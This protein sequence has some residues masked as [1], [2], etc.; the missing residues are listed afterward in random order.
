[1]SLEGTRLGAAERG[2]G[3]RCISHPTWKDDNGCETPSLVLGERNS[4]LPLPSR[5]RKPLCVTLPDI[6]RMPGK[7]RE[8]PILGIFRLPQ[9]PVS[10][11]A[12]FPTAMPRKRAAPPSDVVQ[13]L[14][15]P[16]LKR[17]ENSVRHYHAGGLRRLDV[18]DALLRMAEIL[19]WIAPSMLAKDFDAH[20]ASRVV[21][22]GLNIP[23]NRFASASS[24]KA[25]YMVV[26]S[27]LMA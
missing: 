21:R 17:L 25:M 13:R 26:P 9:L 6:D 3:G 16:R 1:M 10:D 18:R 4:G 15:E 11:V 20:S 19:R 2:Y 12:C 23:A 7:G 5:V 8:L 27:A 14:Q 24:S 22:S